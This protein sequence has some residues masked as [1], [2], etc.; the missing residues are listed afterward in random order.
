MNRRFRLPLIVV[1]VV[2]VCGLAA[3]ISFVNAHAVTVDSRE[4]AL[5]EEVQLDGAFAS[6]S[7]ESLE[8]YSLVVEGAS[9]MSVSEYLNAYALGGIDELAADGGSEVVV[10]DLLI[11]NADN[12][13]GYLNYKNWRLTPPQRNT[14]YYIDYSLWYA[15][16]PELNTGLGSF[17]VTPG[18]AVRLHVPFWHQDTAAALFSG[19]TEYA[20]SLYAPIR[21]GDYE[22]VI[23]NIPRYVVAFS[24]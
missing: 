2:V 12:E 13:T 24:L 23:T 15:A 9:A 10:L 16:L 7:A 6:V 21:C 8:G 14:A 11:S 20:Q 17:Q 1:A 19:G 4:R 22:F 5:G 18:T 3:R